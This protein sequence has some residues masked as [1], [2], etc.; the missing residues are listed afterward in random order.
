MRSRHTRNDVCLQDTSSTSPRGIAYLKANFN[1]EMTDRAASSLENLKEDSLCAE[2][3]RS[4]QEEHEAA[5]LQAK[6]HVAAIGCAQQVRSLLDDKQALLL[7]ADE[8]TAKIAQHTIDQ[9]AKNTKIEFQVEQL[10]AGNIRRKRNWKTQ[11]RR[12]YEP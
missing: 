2:V 9:K 5:S 3:M 7:E 6:S 4:Q 12:Q 8:K 11:W 10:Q 1:T